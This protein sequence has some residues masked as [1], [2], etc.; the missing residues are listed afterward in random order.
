MSSTTQP[1]QHLRRHLLTIRQQLT[2]DIQKEWD[3]CI[4]QNVVAYRQE[5]SFSSLGV[6]FPIKNEPVLHSLY[7]QLAQKGIQLSLPVIHE[8]NQP[9]QFLQWTPGDALTIGE[10]GISIPKQQTV[11][12]IPEA[13]LIPCVGYTQTHHRLGY[14]GGFFDRTLAI[15]TQTRTICVAYT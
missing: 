7:A 8:N 14:G 1:K 6:Y 15:H 11:V 12:P 10:F 2:P 3:E 9:L 13:L 5:Q 4:S